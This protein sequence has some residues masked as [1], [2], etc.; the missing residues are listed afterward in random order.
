MVDL[1]DEPLAE[2]GV[3]RQVFGV[4]HGS[5]RNASA[6][7]DVPPGAVS[8]RPPMLAVLLVRVDCGALADRAPQ[9]V[10]GAT[11]LGQSLTS[12]GPTAA[13]DR[14]CARHDR[15]EHRPGDSVVAALVRHPVAR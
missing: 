12:T 11:E 2:A 9:D 8:A 3:T 5:R 15:G 7:Q 13:T 10:D 4:L 14:A 1:D 6:L